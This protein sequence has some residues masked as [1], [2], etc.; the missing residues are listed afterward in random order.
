[1]KYRVYL[2]FFFELKVMKI[3]KI[4]ENIYEDINKDTDE[5]KLLNH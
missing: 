5:L 1:M 3:L 2:T 4:N